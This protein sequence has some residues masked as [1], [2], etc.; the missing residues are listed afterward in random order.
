MGLG[1]TK[2][3]ADGNNWIVANGVLL[4][5]ATIAVGLRLYARKLQG[6]KLSFNDYAIVLSLVHGTGNPIFEKLT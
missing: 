6:K 5:L 3:S 1:P 4:T 2:I